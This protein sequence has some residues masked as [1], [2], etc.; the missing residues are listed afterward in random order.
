M[1]QFNFDTIKETLNPAKF[2]DQAEKNTQAILCYVEPKE[3]SKTLVAFTSDA[4]NFVRAQLAAFESITTIAK[5]QSE[6]FAKQFTKATAT[7]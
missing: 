7:K 3:L 1:Q 2:I 5:T 4:S 6:E